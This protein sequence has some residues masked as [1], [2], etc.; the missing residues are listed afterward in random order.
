MKGQLV[1]QPLMGR[2]TNEEAKET[3]EEIIK[4]IAGQQKIW[5]H[6]NQIEM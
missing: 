1:S 4:E 6:T 2:G 5:S 3:L